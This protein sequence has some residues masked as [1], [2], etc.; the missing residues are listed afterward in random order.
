MKR[1]ALSFHHYAFM[2]IVLWAT[3]YVVTKLLVGTFSSGPLALI[4]CFV[5][6]V[7][8]FAVMTASKMPSP[9]PRQWYR[10]MIPGFVGLSL[11]SIFFNVG[12]SLINPGTVCI[13]IATAP[14]MTAVMAYFVFKEQLHP[15]AWTAIGL[16]FAGILIMALWDMGLEVNM[17]AVWTA[18]AAFTLALYNILQRNLARTYK[19]L[20]ITAWSFY[21]GT[22]CLLYFLP[23]TVAEIRA[24]SLSQNVMAF[25]LGVGPSALA[26][27]A[28]VK[29]FSLSPKTSYVSNYM[30]LTPVLAI[31]LEL[32]VIA[33]YPDTATIVGGLT[34]MCSLGLFFLAGKKGKAEA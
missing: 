25:Y 28:W 24:A 6:S 27:L 15:L 1:S 17:G 10:F 2:A 30:F 11:Y 7:V 23:Q 29:A 20:Q 12:T 3:S 32:I 31:I 5:A 18:M 22:L 8:L 19:P 4:R 33:S 13:I 9:E 21:F 34:I 26:Y 16:A 14:I